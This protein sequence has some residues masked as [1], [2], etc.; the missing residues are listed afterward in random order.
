MPSPTP[1]W[2]H[3]SPGATAHRGAIASLPTRLRLVMTP[4][5]A[6][7]VVVPVALAVERPQALDRQCELVL[8]D[9]F[10]ATSAQLDA[11]RAAGGPVRIGEPSLIVAGDLMPYCAAAYDSSDRTIV[12]VT[13]DSLGPT[14]EAARL[15]ETLGVVA[16]LGVP[17]DTDWTTTSTPDALAATARWRNNTISAAHRPATGGDGAV[18]VSITTVRQ[19]ILAHGHLG[20]SALP[21]RVVR[22][23]ADGQFERRPSFASPLR[24]YWTSS[25]EGIWP[26]VLAA[27]AGVAP[28]VG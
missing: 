5:D 7:I 12:D 28:S 27:A 26:G 2:L 18:T 9:V 4:E 17:V 14:T 1:V 24:R 23:T 16:A 13:I 20:G 22:H 6:Q 15:A 8:T 11:T 21:I 19:R 25:R 3:P 10:R